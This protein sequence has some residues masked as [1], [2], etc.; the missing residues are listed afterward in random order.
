MFVSK[1]TSLGFLGFGLLWNLI[2]QLIE[3]IVCNICLLLLLYF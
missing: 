2:H 1:V 3:V